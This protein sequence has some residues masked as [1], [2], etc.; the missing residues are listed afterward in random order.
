MPSQSQ[1]SHCL[2]P[3]SGPHPPRCATSELL[4]LELQLTTWRWAGC[5][6]RTWFT[7]HTRDFT[8]QWAL[9]VLRGAPAR[10]GLHHPRLKKRHPWVNTVGRSPGCHPAATPHPI[11]DCPST[12]TRHR[13]I[14][15]SILPG[16]STLRRGAHAH[17]GLAGASPA[18]P[19]CFDSVAD[20]PPGSRFF[21]GAMGLGATQDV[22]RCRALAP[23]ALSPADFRTYPA[24]IPHPSA[25]VRYGQQWKHPGRQNPRPERRASHHPSAT[26]PALL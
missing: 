13:Q 18:S 15:D 4:I 8:P 19:A 20:R 23:L 7:R 10:D 9:A 16:S 12:A 24:H 11:R 1:A 21:G 6:T 5:A 17:P 22:T 2:I 25:R 14:Q 3:D 26:S